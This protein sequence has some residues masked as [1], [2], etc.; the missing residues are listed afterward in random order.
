MFFSNM[1]NELG[2]NRLQEENLNFFGQC[3]LDFIVIFSLSISYWLCYYSC[4]K[5]PP[6]GSPLPST[7]LPSRNA[8][9]SSCPWVMHISSLASPFPILFLTSPCLFCTYQLCTRK[10][11]C[12]F[13]V[14]GKSH[15]NFKWYHRDFFFFCK[16]AYYLEEVNTTYTY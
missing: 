10:F 4:P 3:T 7:F 12:G 16:Q 11:R 9:L 14:W 8:P 1:K 5:F 15:G 6:F 2:R 13:S